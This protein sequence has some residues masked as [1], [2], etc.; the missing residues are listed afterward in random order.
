MIAGQG[1]RDAGIEVKCL[2]I[3]IVGSGIRI[4]AT[5]DGL[6]FITLGIGAQCNI[7]A[8]GKANSSPVNFTIS[9][10]L[11]EERVSEQVTVVIDG[12]NVRTLR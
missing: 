11:G 10:D 1:G 8:P 9:D 7:P 12:R 3:P 2:K 5:S 4:L 6:S